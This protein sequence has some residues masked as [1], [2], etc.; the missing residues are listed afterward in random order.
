MKNILIILCLTMFAGCVPV[1]S[2]PT[3]YS[4]RPGYVDHEGYWYGSTWIPGPYVR[5]YPSGRFTYPSIPR[6]PAPPARHYRTR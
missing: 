3:Y 6:S 4:D 5:R 2:V 1:Y